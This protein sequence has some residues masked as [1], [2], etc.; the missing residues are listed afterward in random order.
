MIPFVLQAIRDGGQRDL[1][2]AGGVFA[3]V[4]L[5]QKL[6]ELTEVGQIH[7]HP[8]MDDHG[9]AVGAGFEYLS[10]SSKLRPSPLASIYLGPDYSKEECANALERWGIPFSE[11]SDIEAEV[12]EL[13]AQGK[14]V[15]RFKGRMEYGS[16]ALGNRSILYRSDDPA[17]NEWLNHHLR[18]NEYMPFA[19]VSLGEHLDELYEGG[20]KLRECLRFM[21]TS[22][23]CTPRMRKLSP[24]AIHVDGT[25]R[26]QILFEED[27]PS[28]HRLLRLFYEKTGNP[29]LINT[30]FNMHEEPIV[31]SP[32]D[33][34]RAF[35]ASGLPYLA[36]NDFLVTRSESSLPL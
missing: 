34:C 16:R 2:L 8:A 14:V 36:I 10:K 15:V 27:N 26:P 7:V 11:K 28:F 6:S 3:N 24:G 18:R 23:R 19:P 21:C 20:E 12:A 35:L 32:D 1:V 30:S 31:C 22:L 33:A 25:A 4:K 9:L 13:L 29:S 5:V 17:V